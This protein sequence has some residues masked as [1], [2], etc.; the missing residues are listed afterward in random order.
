M[1]HSTPSTSSPASL[2]ISSE[3]RSRLHSIEERIVDACERSKRSRS[4]VTLCAVTKSVPVEKVQAAIDVGLRVFGENRVQEAAQKIPQVQAP[5]DVKWHFIG[6]LQSNKA[7]RA[8]ELFDAIQTVDSL[9]LAERLDRIAK[10]LDRR[11]TVMLEVNLGEESTKSG[12]GEGDVLEVA[13]S[14]SGLPHLELRGLM[15]VPPFLEPVELVRPYF[16]RLRSLRDQA[17][18]RNPNLTDLS[19]GMTHDFEIAI[20]EGATMIRVGTALFGPRDN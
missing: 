4:D 2:A 10:E 1:T 6:H 8:I 14:I 16:S 20:E 19:M 7:R 3:L 5:S 9:S 11:L 17:K 18:K 12:M 15:T 13:E